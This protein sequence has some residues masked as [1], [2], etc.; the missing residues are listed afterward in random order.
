M[1]RLAALSLVLPALLTLPR[2]AFAQESRTVA[3]VVFTSGV[4]GQFGEPRC[5]DGVSFDP[6]PF[7][8]YARALRTA[9]EG[10]DAFVVD[11]GGFF[12]PH[13][14]GRFALETDRSALVELVLGLGYDALAFAAK[15]L[16]GARTPVALLAAQ[17]RAAGLPFIAS[18]L[19]CEAS[20]MQ[21]C[22]ALDDASDPLR[23]HEVAGEKVAFLAFI[24]PAVLPHVAEENRVGVALDPLVDAFQR[25][26]A[27]ARAL[28]A[29]LIV[30]SVDNG[31]SSRAIGET[32]T[33]I[34]SLPEDARPDLVLSARAGRRMLYARPASFRPPIA[35]AHPGRGASVEVRRRDD[36]VGLEMLVRAFEAEEP[37]A[38]GGGSV[39]ALT[40]FAERIGPEYCAE[41]S[42]PLAGGT[43]LTAIDAAGMAEL[44][45]GAMRVTAD[46]E[47]AIVNVGMIA[48]GFE[49][50]A[51]HVLTASDAQIGVQFD[52]SM[53]IASVDATYLTALA[54][55]TAPLTDVKVV[56]LAVTNPGAAD[57][58]ITINGRA[59][60]PRGHYRIVVPRF[61]AAGGDEIL[62][63]GAHFTTVP[64][65]SVRASLLAWLEAPRS[66]DPRTALPNPARRLEWSF[67][68]SSDASLGTSQVTTRDPAVYT[69]AQFARA[70]STT[71]GMQN[72]L[73]L[74]AR[75]S[76]LSWENQALVRYRTATGPGAAAEESDD[77]ISLR[78][79]FAWVDAR[80]RHPHWYVPEATG[81]AYVE[82]EFTPARAQRHFLV[83]P[84]AGLRFS[85]TSVLAL[86]LQAGG[87]FELFGLADPTPGVG[88]V[89]T[90]ASWQFFQSGHRSGTL[91]GTF[92]WFLSGLGTTPVNTLRGNLDLGIQLNRVLGVS[93][94]STLYAAKYEQ[95]R[96][97]SVVNTTF[98]L[99]LA[100]YVRTQ[101]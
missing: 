73:D 29:T 23:I 100:F 94:T 76:R 15:D 83:R 11:T 67:A 38:E 79:T 99:R 77:L 34:E 59:L 31:S 93:V 89:L 27:E 88:A 69:D 28:G 4:S 92:D 10:G 53:A 3:H 26:V 65:G 13:G 68:F 72:Q 35:A 43:L 16:Q 71:Y 48:E 25:R 58:A 1:R 78:S 87:A 45:A 66:E 49:R 91:A 18:N 6:G 74:V 36:D 56:G 40:T 12:E 52:E 81:E 62:P 19:R 90:L 60:D 85:L 47:I 30:A 50:P 51:G 44:T 57:E 22:D 64:G 84:T 63:D 75:S 2:A 96:F 101:R 24:D 20:A 17:L 9:S 55:R 41:L 95:Y 86:K 98:N 5:A 70:D 37:S 42:R 39:T 82:T 33:L 32:L 61:L 80:T 7:T 8:P 14:T 21:L 54:R 46:A 97:A